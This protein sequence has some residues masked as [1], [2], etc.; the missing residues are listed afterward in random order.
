MERKI[1]VMVT[2]VMTILVLFSPLV[3]SGTAQGTK[4]KEPITIGI[5]TSL[6]GFLMDPGVCH[7]QGIQVAIKGAPPK[8][9]GRP[10]KFVVEDEAS[11]PG[12]AVNKVRKLVE[13]DKASILIGPFHGGA[14]IGIAAYVQKMKVPEI[15][16][17]AQPDEVSIK[18][19]W[20][21]CII[22]T[23]PKGGSCMGA[24]AY[25][26]LGYRT[27]TTLTMDY[28]SGYEFVG[29]F[30]DIFTAKGGDVIQKQAYPLGTMDF[31]PYIT[32]LKKADTV[33]RFVSFGPQEMGFQRQLH[34]FGSKI[35]VTAPEGQPECSYCIKQYKDLALGITYATPYVWTIDTPENK[36]FVEDFKK[37]WG[38]DVPGAMAAIA[39]TDVQLALEAIRKTGGDTSGEALTSAL[40]KISFKSPMGPISFKDRLG[41]NLVYIVTIEK[42]SGNY[43]PKILAT[44]K[45]EAEKSG[46]KVNYKPAKIK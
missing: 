12:T 19:P 2:M 35:P 32:A 34:D 40:D 21:Y 30:Q 31:A 27:A 8:I 5:I 13:T 43:V 36:K 29:G 37:M 26:V 3:T 44:Y 9:A 1:F 11:D 20:L 39:Y 28:E 24:Y 17:Y 6:T 38:G 18:Y 16:L 33:C 42:I 7:N 41:E 15:G 10:I 46:N 25:D 22:G 14:V 23:I 4:E 45:A